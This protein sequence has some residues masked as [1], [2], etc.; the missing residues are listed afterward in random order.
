[1][2]ESNVQMY[3]KNAF[4]K[5][6][7][8]IFKAD[9]YLENGGVETIYFCCRLEIGVKSKG[10]SSVYDKLEAVRNIMNATNYNDCKAFAQHQK[11][12]NA[13]V[14]GI[15]THGGNKRQSLIEQEMK[16]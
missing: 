3:L 13:F 14:D 12:N 1:M 8:K 4:Y 7:I 5:A 16:F 2:I 6:D 9:L 10:N 15:E 11:S